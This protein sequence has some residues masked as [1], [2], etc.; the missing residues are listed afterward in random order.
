MTAFDIIGD[1]ELAGNQDNGVIDEFIQK[2]VPVKKLY[3][4]TIV[5]KQAGHIISLVGNIAVDVNVT[6]SLNRYLVNALECHYEL[7]QLEENT[8]KKLKQLRK[9]TIG[10]SVS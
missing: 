4:Y 10:K 2:P 5:L 3:D 7:M 6:F 9:R 1:T 8:R